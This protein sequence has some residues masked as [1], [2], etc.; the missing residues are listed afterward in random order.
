MDKNK[1]FIFHLQN[2]FL[3][4]HEASI[5]TLGKYTTKL[6]TYVSSKA[7]FPCAWKHTYKISGQGKSNWHHLPGHVQSIRHC[8]AQYPCL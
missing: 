7:I 5:L 3:F 6:E 4:R 2:I 1:F 8:P